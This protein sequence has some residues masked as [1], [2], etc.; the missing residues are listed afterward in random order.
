[1]FTA[2]YSLTH[3]YG[4]EI[5]LGFVFICAGLYLALCCLFRRNRSKESFLRVLLGLLVSDIVCDAV[6]MAA[7]YPGGEYYNYG[8]GGAYMALLAWPSLLMIT[9]FC[10]TLWNGKEEE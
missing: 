3:V 7:F 8:L 9:G 10:V 4:A 1:M 2:F 6:W 5:W